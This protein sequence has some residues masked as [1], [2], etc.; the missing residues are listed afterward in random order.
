MAP[1][2]LHVE[3]KDGVYIRKK[4]D[5]FLGSYGFVL[6]IDKIVFVSDRGCNIVKAVVS[7]I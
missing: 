4:L 3:K 6:L 5:E 2:E 1:R 7:H